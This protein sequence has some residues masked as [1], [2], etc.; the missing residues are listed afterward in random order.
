MT[1]I[2]KPVT[3]E[4]ACL[5]R[6]IALIVTLHPRILEI[7][8]KGTRHKYSIAYD[9]CMWLAIKREADDKRREK[10]ATQKKGRR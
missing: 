5:E 4:S 8:I 7:H 6:G 1:K 3:R 10:A 9:K 2:T